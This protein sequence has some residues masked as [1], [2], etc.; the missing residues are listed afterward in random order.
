MFE[1]RV[2]QLVNYL[3]ALKQTDPTECVKVLDFMEDYLSSS[4]EDRNFYDS[5]LVAWKKD[6]D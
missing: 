1:Q 3:K 6:M 2:E 4:E 5:F